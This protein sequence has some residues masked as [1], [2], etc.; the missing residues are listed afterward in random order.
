MPVGLMFFDQKMR[1]PIVCHDTQNNDSGHKDPQYNDICPKKKYEK[2]HNI[3]LG[4]ILF[5]DIT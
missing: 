5:S 2:Q 3:M 4:G 1:S